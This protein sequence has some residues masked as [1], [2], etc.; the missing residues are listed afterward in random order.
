MILSNFNAEVIAN[1]MASQL[2]GMTSLAII[3]L[4]ETGI[5]VLVND[6]VIEIGPSIVEI[7]GKL[8]N[9]IDTFNEHLAEKL[10]I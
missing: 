4:D 3:E 6:F 8:H 1:L 9:E 5:S 10:G 7:N 2:D